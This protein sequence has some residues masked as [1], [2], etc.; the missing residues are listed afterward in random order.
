MGVLPPLRGFLVTGNL[1]ICLRV[2]EPPEE[3]LLLA[4]IPPSGRSSPEGEAGKEGGVVVAA[5]R[6][7]EPHHE[8]RYCFYKLI[9]SRGPGDGRVSFDPGVGWS[10]PEFRGQDLHGGVGRGE[11]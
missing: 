1:K 11:G 7:D 5:A 4:P 6:F 9:C 2:V 10:E 8:R 3:T